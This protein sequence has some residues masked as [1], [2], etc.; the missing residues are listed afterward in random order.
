MVGLVLLIACGNVANLLIARAFMRQREIA[1]R[2]SLGSSRGRLVRQLLV[3]SLVLSFAG[4]L[5]GLAIAFGLTRSLLALVPQEGQPLLIAASPDPRI[6]AFTVVLTF[7]TGI[8]FG[9]L[10]ALRASRPDPWT[11]LKDTVGSI[12][13]GGGSVF[14]RK[15]LVVA[16]VALSFLLVFGAGLFVRSLQNLKAADT[17]VALD[18]LLT[19]QLSPALSGYDNERAQVFY[20]QLL[21]R[22]RAE[23]GVTSA[24][25]ATVPIL[26]GD[27]WDSSMAVEGHQAK[28]GEDMQAFMNAVS[29][30]YFKT[31]NIAL[32]DGRDFRTSDA[33]EEPTVVIVNRAFADHFFPGRSAVGRRV[34]YGGGPDAKLNMEIIGVV[35]NSLY[36]GPREGV[37]RQAFLPNYGKM[38]G[39][40]YVRTRT[41]SAGAFNIVR[42]DVRQLDAG[43]PVY[44]MKTVEGQLD[45]TL[46]TD[47][48]I[49][50]LSA[51]FGALATLLASIGL[52]G[53]M[54]FVVARRRKELGIR[55]ALGAQPGFVMWLVMREVLLLLAVGLA[56][57]IP[58]A[59][60][61]GRY[62]SAQ[63]YGLQPRDPGIALATVLLL[64]V[65]SAV[66]GLIP[67]QRAS[68]IDPILALRTE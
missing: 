31:M 67:A 36:E 43:M 48:L 47:R 46:L 59:M 45:E 23:P 38:S 57:G 66:A 17:G 27:E 44:S 65:V 22:V 53:V 18:N 8:V 32:L 12:A 21:E 13:G 6:L 52:Y 3:E 40:F 26:S 25:L 1:V 55:L 19:F 42:N 30:G 33:R 50:M 15:G 5:L 20:Q 7:I 14:L 35:A 62:V 41:P 56:V 28:D 49:A 51:G 61:L 2:L 16:Q 9:L 10:P 24:A 34:G 4:G 39:T 37:H 68:R 60:A 64:T 54:A 11:T 58:A 63:L 29:P